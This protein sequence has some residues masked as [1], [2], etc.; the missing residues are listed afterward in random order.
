MF[1][2]KE[3]EVGHLLGHGRSEEIVNFCLNNHNNRELRPFSVT[4]READLDL[5]LPVKTTGGK[6][7]K[8]RLSWLYSLYENDFL[9]Y[10]QKCSDEKLF[11][12][13]D[14]RYAINI[15]LQ[16]GN[17]MR[18]ECHVDSNPIEGLL[19][20]TDHPKGNGGELVIS[21]NSLSKGPAEIREDSVV[22]YPKKD[23]LVFFDAR[24]NP[25][26][27]EPLSD[28][29]NIR[30]VVAMNYYTHN[31]PESSRPKDLN[32]HLFGED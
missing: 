28:E 6:L 30:V 21:I 3:F 10:A 11:V 18:Y 22:L 29:N 1:D 20:L 25:H 19:Y 5:I 14:E 31:C 7:I 17:K 27:V 26:Y 23:H 24:E 8:E 12:A 4:S 16:K 2:W 13:S 32:I 9:A 15:N